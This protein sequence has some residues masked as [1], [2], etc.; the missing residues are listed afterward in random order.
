MTSVAAHEMVSH[1]VG[2]I[3]N[4]ISFNYQVRLLTDARW[5]IQIGSNAILGGQ[6]PTSFDAELA[7]PVAGRLVGL[8]DARINHARLDESRGTVLLEFSNGESLRLE[9]DDQFEGWELTGPNREK[10]VC[11]PG[12]DLAVWGAVIA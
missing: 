8:R 5:E 11:L 7:S 4:T 12:G 9:P 1:L 6:D 3:I 10:I 2:Q